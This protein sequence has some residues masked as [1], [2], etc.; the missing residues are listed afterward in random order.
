MCKFPKEIRNF[1]R[2]VFMV[3]FLPS[4]RRKVWRRRKWSQRRLWRRSKDRT[5]GRE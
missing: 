3:Y 2:I 4:K 5:K 1:A